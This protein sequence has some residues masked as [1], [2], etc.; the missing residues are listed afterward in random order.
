[1]LMHGRP[2]LHHTYF[3]GHYSFAQLPQ[4]RRQT[5]RRPATTADAQET[6]DTGPETGAGTQGTVS[7]QR[8]VSKA[9]RMTSEELRARLLRNA[10]RTDAA[11]AGRHLA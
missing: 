4:R 10:Q 9:P 11:K 5:P 1:M 2:L 7:K 6:S 8:K 3:A